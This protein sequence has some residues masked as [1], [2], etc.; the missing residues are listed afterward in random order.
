M[1]STCASFYLS[2]SQ[3]PLWLIRDWV[4]GWRNSLVARSAARWV[5]VTVV[6]AIPSRRVLEELLVV[7]EPQADEKKAQKERKSPPRKRRRSFLAKGIVV[8]THVQ[9]VRVRCRQHNPVKLALPCVRGCSSLYPRREIFAKRKE[10]NFFPLAESRE[11]CLPCV[12]AR[13]NSPPRD[14]ENRL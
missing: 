8:R 10:R 2:C 6:S 1:S 9:S 5:N 7:E 13:A 4:R 3:A 11:V 12:C 14:W